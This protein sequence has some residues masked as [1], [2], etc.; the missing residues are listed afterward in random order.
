MDEENTNE[1]QFCSA[2]IA[3]FDQFGEIDDYAAIVLEEFFKEL[4]SGKE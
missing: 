2:L 3:F 1:D 4:M